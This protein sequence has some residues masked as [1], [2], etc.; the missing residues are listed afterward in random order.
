MSMFLKR[1][2]R[3]RYFIHY[4]KLLTPVS[5]DKHS[6]VLHQLRVKFEWT[7]PRKFMRYANESIIFMVFY[8]IETLLE[9]LYVSFMVRLY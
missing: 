8:L 6:F 2:L 3:A 4:P 5:D 7:K 9:A 1:M